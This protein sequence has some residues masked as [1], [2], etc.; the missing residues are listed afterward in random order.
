MAWASI[1]NWQDG[2]VDNN[3]GTL[4][5]CQWKCEGDYRTNNDRTGCELI[6]KCEGDA[7]SGAQPINGIWDSSSSVTNTLYESLQKANNNYCSY[8]CPSGTEP[9]DCDSE[10]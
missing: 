9:Y 7:P 5:W 4:L 2:Y 8:V 6:P 1:T 3:V 10:G